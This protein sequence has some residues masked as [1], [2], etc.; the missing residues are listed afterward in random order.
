MTIKAKNIYDYGNVFFKFIGLSLVTAALSSC[1]LSSADNARDTIEGDRIAVL[2]FEQTLQADPQLAN[3]Q[4]TLPKPYV[5]ENWAQAGGN[6]HHL[7]QHLS[8]ADAPKRLWSRDVGA[9]VTGRKAIVS[10]PVVKDGVLYAIDSDAK[11][12]A[13]DANNGRVLW[14][15]KFE[16]ENETTM[17]SYGG[18]VTVGDNVLYV[19]TGYG[20]FS[21]LNLSDG[22]EIWGEEIGVPMRGSPTYADGR[23]FGIT[24][25]NHVYALD[26]QTGE[27]LWDEVGIAEN[28]GLTGNA[29]PA[30]VD[31]TVIVTYS[32]GEVY[33]MRVEN[34]RVLWTDTLNR[35]G[36]LTAMSSL[37]DIDG[38]PVVYD[39]NV[40][41]ISQSGRM[42]SVNLR[43]GVRQWEQNYGSEDTPWVVGEFI[44]V[45]TTESEVICITRREGRVVW[46]RQLERFQDPDLRKE[47]V[48]WHGP[49]VAGDRVIVTS[50]HGYALS[51]S[52]Y[53]G[54]VI[55]GVDLPDDASMGPIVSNE[56]LYFM[57]N[58]GEIIAMR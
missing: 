8:I 4:I 20:H 16:M 47:P 1:G 46:I 6:V 38:H 52:P 30:V 22:S 23:V 50:S 15:V 35:Q 56:T 40:Y 49:V 2:T 9:G 13:L 41:L 58:D 7:M 31:N 48:S 51:L 37:R 32:S 36:R 54:E 43:S 44:Y 55:G 11:V 26:A 21:A 29:S 27:I 12:S 18:G 25:D 10:E 17:L 3:L 39:G 53:T 57:L 33:A 19:V 24:H 34:G 5:N 42:A 14:N 28:A 45:V